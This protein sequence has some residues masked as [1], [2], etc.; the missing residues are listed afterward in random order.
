MLRAGHQDFDFGTSK[1][2]GDLWLSEAGG[3][4]YVN[5][6]LDSDTAVEFQIAIYDGSVRASAY[7]AHDF[8]L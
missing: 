2:R 8:I 7:S 6:N 5:G 1:G 4:T 3:V